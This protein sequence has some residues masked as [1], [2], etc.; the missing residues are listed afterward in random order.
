MEEAFFRFEVEVVKLGDFE[1][2]MYCALMVGHICTGGD[3]N[4]VHVDSDSR[5]KTFMFE[6]DIAVN[7][8]HHH[9]E[10]RWRIGESEVHDRRLKKSVSGFE[11]C[12]LFVSFPNA[13]IVVPP[14]NIKFRVDVC[15]TEVTDE[16]HN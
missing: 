2:V 14:A 16:V 11:C 12:L 4:V 3:S 8:I 10:C 15:V 9:L 13:Y 6:N 7:V 5:T 1:D